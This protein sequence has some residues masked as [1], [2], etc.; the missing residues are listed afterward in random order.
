MGRK[1]VVVAMSGGVDSSAAAALLKEDG[2]EVIG[3]S[4]Q[5]W[6]SSG[7]DSAATEGSCCSPGDIYDARR[8]A[9]TLGI[10]YYV[11]NME[12]TFSREVVDYFVKSYLC[13]FTP[14]PCVKCNEVMKFEALLNKALNL[15][16]AFLATGHYARIIKDNGTYRLLK[17]VDKAKDQ[18]YFLF[19]M[20]Q[21][22]LEKVLFPLGGLKKSETR[23]Y[24]KRFNLGVA[25]KR[26]SQEICFIGNGDYSDFVSAEA[27]EVSG[28]IIDKG[29]H[30]LGSHRGLFRYTIGQRKGLNIKNASG[31]FYVTGMDAKTNRLVVGGDGELYSR[32][33]FA[34][35]L[36]WVIS[37]PASE[38]K[39]EAKVRYRHTP[40][41]CSIRTEG[42]GAAVMFNAPQKSITPGQ[43]VV[44][45]RGD[46]VMG[47]GWIERALP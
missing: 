15:G 6:D 45:Y 21:R 1:R 39:V 20:K 2:F 29:G 33:L 42:N 18:S 36:T 23:E 31:P 41:D 25:E 43:A 40:A 30:V 3:I 44:F 34:R 32:G 47:G 10:P 26:D 8:V 11:V 19:T 4:M 27:A 12:E 35:D 22:H 7:E 13:G 28:E 37:A 14:N 17:A 16:A 38:E 9:D 5:L 46:E 24:A